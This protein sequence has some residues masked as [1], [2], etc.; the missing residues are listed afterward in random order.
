MLNLTVA[1]TYHFSVETV[2]PII[3]IRWQGTV[4]WRPGLCKAFQILMLTYKPTRAFLYVNPSK[5]T[6]IL[7]V[8]CYYA[9][10]GYLVQ[11]STPNVRRCGFTSTGISLDSSTTTWILSWGAPRFAPVIYTWF[12]HATFAGVFKNGVQLVTSGAASGFVNGI[13]VQSGWRLRRG[14]RNK[15][16][17]RSTQ[18]GRT[19]SWRHFVPGGRGLILHNS[20]RNEL[21]S[22]HIKRRG[23]D[24]F[25]RSWRF[26][27]EN[28]TATSK[29]GILVDPSLSRR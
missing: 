17:R 22:I 5:K 25:R 19:M 6:Y 11:N 1:A 21:S 9:P 7:I 26:I 2:N 28:E 4:T 23:R 20:F 27:V 24:G 15:F 10:T 16:F 13:V 12:G 8:K 29:F 18:R 3:A 14:H